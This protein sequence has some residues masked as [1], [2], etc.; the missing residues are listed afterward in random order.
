MSEKKERGFLD[1][2]SLQMKAKPP[3][4]A[5]RPASLTIKNWMNKVSITVFSNVEGA[6]KHGIFGLNLY[7]T[8]FMALLAGLE[9]IANSPYEEGKRVSRKLEVFDK[10]GNDKTH[11]GD[12]VYGRDEKGYMYLCLVSPQEDFP[13]IIFRF[14]FPRNVSYSGAED[15]SEESRLECLGRINLWRTVMPQVL[16]TQFVDESNS[17]KGGYGNKGGYNKSSGGN[18]GG[19]SPSNYSEDDLPF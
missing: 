19:G 3:E 10:P 13:K 5:K 14:T 12:L 4:G 17:G 15:P 11:Y 18:S 6:P 2:T 8:Q 16:L 9:E 1:L 7:P